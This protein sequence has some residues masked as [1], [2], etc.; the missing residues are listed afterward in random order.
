MT[1]LT[2]YH[3][4]KFDDPRDEYQF[5]SYALLSMK[6]SDFHVLKSINT[7]SYG[8]VYLMKYRETSLLYAVKIISDK[9]DAKVLLTGLKLNKYVKHP[10][11]IR[12]YGHFHDKWV[13][14]DSLFLI[15][16]YFD[17]QDIE[18]IMSENKTAI[19]DILPGI[20]LKVFEAINYLHTD[21]LVHQDIKLE[22]IMIRGADVRLIDLDFIMIKQDI[23]ATYVIGTPYYLSPEMLT[24]NKLY[25]H[26]TD[27][28]SMGIATYK[29]LTTIFPFTGQTQSELFT[30]IKYGLPNLDILPYIYYNL[31]KGLL[32]KDP[33]K[34][35]RFNRIM[36]EL[37]IIELE[38]E[39]I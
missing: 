37:Q 21:S 34:R 18:H 10:Y 3:P 4:T 2:M 19:V 36:K 7:G 20:L 32:N 17:G 33:D 27:I 30:K 24:P 12:Y 5:G 13:G 29:M 6:L 25:D 28:W 15:M 9:K 1:V 38:Y 14:K 31:I 26:R 11:I 35:W 16:E 23:T 8:S 39:N 22:N